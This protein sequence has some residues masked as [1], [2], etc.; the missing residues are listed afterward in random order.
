M[1]I[2]N[3]ISRYIMNKQR[4]QKDEMVSQD[5]VN[6]LKQEISTFRFELLTVLSDNGFSTPTVHQ[7]KTSSKLDR[8]WKN[9]SAATEGQAE[10][11]MEEAG[12]DDVS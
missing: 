8:M 7:A 1:V 10:T 12:L 6:E 11:L 2:R 9:L 3:L 4:P 5:D